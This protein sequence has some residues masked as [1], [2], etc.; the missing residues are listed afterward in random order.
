MES[1]L[2]D[3]PLGFALGTNRLVDDGKGGKIEEVFFRL[4]FE[5]DK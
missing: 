3:M 5:L 1:Y 4:V 2:G